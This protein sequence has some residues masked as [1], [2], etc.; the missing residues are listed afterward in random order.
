M[1]GAPLFEWAEIN[2]ENGKI[3]HIKTSN[4][5]KENQFVASVTLNGEVLDRTF[6][7]HEEIMSGGELIFE[8]TNEPV[9]TN[10]KSP[11][12]NKIY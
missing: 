5:A 7:T 11:E 4:F 3:F 10:L 6:I 12:P 8:M 1:L 9:N 2:L